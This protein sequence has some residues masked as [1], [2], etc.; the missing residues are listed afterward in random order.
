MVF[1]QL[2]ITQWQ[3]RSGFKA[4]D[5]QCSQ[6]S[7][8]CGPLTSNSGTNLAL[9]SQWVK[10]HSRWKLRSCFFI[11]SYS[12]LLITSGWL[13]TAAIHVSHRDRIYSNDKVYFSHKICLEMAEDYKGS[14]KQL[15]SWSLSEKLCTFYQLCLESIPAFEISNI[16]HLGRKSKQIKALK[17]ITL[18]APELPKRKE[19]MNSSPKHHVLFPVW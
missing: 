8:F 10:P 18:L 1:P 6:Y 7:F 13:V 3:L 5:T 2:R 16:F 11:V 12:K 17:V 4:Y 14:G 19:G 15:L 9:A